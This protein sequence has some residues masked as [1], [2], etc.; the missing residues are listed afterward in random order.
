[1]VL[2]GKV[3]IIEACLKHGADINRTTECHGS[4]LHAVD[5][6]SDRYF[7]VLGYL[8][9]HGNYLSFNLKQCLA[10]QCKATGVFVSGGVQTVNFYLASAL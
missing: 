10:N 3:D 6:T 4:L 8:L 7:H 1:M 5:F 9:K 2:N